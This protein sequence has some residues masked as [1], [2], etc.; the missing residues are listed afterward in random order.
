M[1][2]TLVVFPLGYLKIRLRSV[3]WK[4]S[5]YRYK[6][7]LYFVVLNGWE[8]ACLH[9]ALVVFH[10]MSSFAQEQLSKYGRWHL[11]FVLQ[12]IINIAQSVC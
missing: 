10:G 2:D 7:I 9:P 11:L 8:I 3:K 12:T 4:E 5:Q 1:E 6:I